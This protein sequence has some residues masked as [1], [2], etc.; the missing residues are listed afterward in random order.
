[1][2]QYVMLIV[3]FVVCSFAVCLTIAFVQF[4]FEE[5]GDDSASDDSDC[6]EDHADELR[7]FHKNYVKSEWEPD[8]GNAES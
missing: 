2:L 7:Q 3:G 8:C 4:L 6:I 5:S 1:M